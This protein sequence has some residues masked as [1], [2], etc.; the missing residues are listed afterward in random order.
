MLPSYKGT[1]GRIVTTTKPTWT[2]ESDYCPLTGDRPERVCEKCNG[3]GLER[4]VVHEAYEA[5]RYTTVKCWRCSGF[6]TLRGDDA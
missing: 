2:T 1:G 4:S 5:F 6:G 3:S